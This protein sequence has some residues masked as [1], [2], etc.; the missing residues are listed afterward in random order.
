MC[1]QNRTTQFAIDSKHPLARCRFQVESAVNTHALGSASQ[2]I[3]L[4]RLQP[5][6]RR[7]PRATW[8]RVCLRRSVR[9]CGPV[10]YP[11]E[12][13]DAPEDNANT[14]ARKLVKQPAD[15]LR[16]GKVD[17]GDRFRVED[18]V[19]DGRRRFLN[20][21]AN[22]VSEVIGARIKQIRAVAI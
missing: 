22:L 4:G 6:S 1:H 3:K 13:S 2:P 21:F 5:G 9:R 10:S 20:Q 7:G 8:G 15:G 16:C 14:L 19:L 18:E 11:R 12:G 17:V